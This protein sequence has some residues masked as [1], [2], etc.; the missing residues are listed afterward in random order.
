[1]KTIDA[2]A[3]RAHLVAADPVMARLIATAGP[4]TPRP[5]GGDPFRSLAR[6]IIFQ[7]LA[8]AA[9]GAIFNRFVGL[10]ELDP[11]RTG[12]RRTDPEWSA[13]ADP[14]PEPAAVLALSDE[15]MRSAGLS[16]QKVASL[17]SLA[18]H[19]AEKRLSAELFDEWED[20]EIIAHLTQVR[21][22]GRWTAEMYLM[23]H[24]GRPDVLPVNDL[25]L[26]RAMEK[27]YGLSALPKTADVQRIGA[28]WRPWATVACWYL[29]RSF[30]VVVPD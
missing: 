10:F 26:N 24:L 19:F 9:A 30:D 28:P 16:R 21:G 7:Q 2:D 6:A 12:L 8:G 17:R 29:W 27:L 20:E 15:Q 4:F 13:M 18:E 5:E 23:F 3:A 11:G 22:I 1:M 25:G 14:F